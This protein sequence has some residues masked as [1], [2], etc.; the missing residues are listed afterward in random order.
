MKNIAI[1]ASGEGTNA[2]RIIRYFKAIVSY[3][4][5]ICKYFYAAL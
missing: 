2:E 1:L 4:I 5:I 3:K